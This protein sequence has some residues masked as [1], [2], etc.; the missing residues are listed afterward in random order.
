[1]AIIPKFNSDNSIKPTDY[2]QKVKDIIKKLE[3]HLFYK[4]N[5]EEVNVEEENGVDKKKN[6]KYYKN[7]ILP[8]LTPL[9]VNAKLNELLRIYRP[10]NMAEAKALNDENYLE[11]LHYYMILMS[12][13]NQYIG[14]VPSKQTFCA[15]ANITTSVYNELLQDPNFNQ[16]FNSIEDY[17]IDA[18]FTSSQAGLV[19]NKTTISKLQM[20]DAGH[21]LIQSPEAITFVNNNKIDKQQVNLQFDRLEGIIKSLNYNKNKNN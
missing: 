14:I 12:Y 7:Q 11:A 8:D 20:K 9:Q 6:N 4:L 3:E 21:N 18:N 10:M 17:L 16:V 15:F 1:M 13:I 19:D 2:E 5:K